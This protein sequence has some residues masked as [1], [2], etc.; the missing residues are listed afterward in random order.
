MVSIVSEGNEPALQPL[1][2]PMATVDLVSEGNAPASQPLAEPMA[3]VDLVSEGNEPALQPLAEP[4][5]SVSIPVT[6]VLLVTVNE[7]FVP[8]EPAVQVPIPFIVT[9]EVV[10]FTS[11]LL[12]VPAG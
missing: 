1:A 8:L 12:T 11:G 7:G 5:V 2:E 10:K 9:D 3:T 4:I 6:T